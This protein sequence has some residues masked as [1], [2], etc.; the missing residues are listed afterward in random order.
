LDR[1]CYIRT[2]P[3]IYISVTICSNR[4]AVL[5]DMMRLYG[6]GVFVLLLLFL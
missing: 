5:G 3:Q 6:R 4:L 2:N 1:E